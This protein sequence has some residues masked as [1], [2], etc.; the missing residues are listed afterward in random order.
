MTTPTGTP[1][2]TA[3][4]AG[5]AGILPWAGVWRQTLGD[6]APLAVG[7]V[8]VAAAAFLSAA[9]PQAI[10]AAATAEVSAALGSADAAANLR[11]TVPVNTDY[12]P[13][14]QPAEIAARMRD[15]VDAGIPA[16]LRG[17]LAPPVTALVGPELKAGI[18]ADRQGYVRFI[19][20][21]DGAGPA[22]SWIE[23]RAPKA[24]SD[25]SHFPPE[26]VTKMT[27]EVAVSDAAATLMGVHAGAKLPVDNSSAQRLDVEVSGI[28]RA[29]DPDD[30]A[31]S[32][33]PNLLTPKVVG[34]SAAF[35][36]VGLL[37]SAESLPYAA[38]GVFPTPMTR[39]YTYRVVPSPLDA[40]RAAEVS[41][42]ARSLASGRKV[43]NI[44]E[45]TPI[46]TTHLDRVID[47]ALARVAS[48]TAQSSVLLIGLLSVALLVQLLAAGLVVER[49][50]AVLTQ[51]RARGATLAAIGLAGAAESVPLALVAGLIGMFAATRGGV[52]PWAWVTPTL[53]AAALPQP[54]LA[55]RTAA[56]ASGT[57]RPTAG[58]RQRFTAARV[59]RLA[60]EVAVGLV[61]LASLA[62]L[63][64]RGATAA[65]GSLWSD[66]VVLA[67]PVLVALAVALALTR[68]QPPLLAAARNLAVRSPGAV[69]LLA[70]ARTR[71]GGLATTALVTAT[72]I[73]A[74]AA[75]IAPTV[76]QG[77]VD[78]AWDAVGADAGARLTGA[79]SLPPTVSALDGTDGLIVATATTIAGAQAIGPQLDRSVTIVAVDAEALAR[80]VAAT[81]TADVPGLGSLASGGPDAVP[82]LVPAGQGWD[83]ASLRWGEDSVTMR[84]VGAAPALP[85]SLDVD[86]PAVVVDRRLLGQAV[87]HDIGA[88][89]AWVA[90]PD[91]EA[92]L[93]GALG[94]TGARVVTR[95]GWLAEQAARPVTRALGGLFVGAGAVALA[96][97]ALAVA[98]LAASGSRARTIA[99][100]QLRAAGTPRAAAARVAWLEVAVPTVVAGAV[101][102]ATGLGLAGLLVVALD[103]T[104][105]TGGLHPPA[106][107]IPWW[108]LAIPIALGLVAR[109]AIALAAL[110]HRA[111]RLGLLMRAG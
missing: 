90:G 16:E 30:D 91:A 27:V 46:V 13:Q 100:A 20:V 43:F 3:P 21:S 88:S 87:G 28:F 53:V 22:V 111:E 42:Q 104:S 109:V 14:P 41:T 40:R 1:T 29:D 85:P 62:T 99:L 102:I 97:G 54:V 108:T 35:A 49:R 51:W 80:L 66:A 72:A 64:L 33:E 96:L 68:L 103:L 110:S 47:D 37:T 55:I 15:E 83:G 82:V 11:V 8:V 39:T 7:M 31:W 58:T 84:S 77:R 79:G 19:Y 94:G 48:G 4:T 93:V 45:A 36:S 106:L 18:I 86:G 9:V 105:V 101:G 75:T 78:A 65:A 52:P 73:A 60:A 12:G 70:A 44:P 76:V 95:P 107:V 89:Q 24:T 67:A 5:R 74:I 71:A 92:R 2:A 6:A 63:V 98:L 25:T 57:T 23:G 56:R 26:D 69:P 34:G 61:A 50:T 10:D 17:I 38:F 59:R 32:V 81:P